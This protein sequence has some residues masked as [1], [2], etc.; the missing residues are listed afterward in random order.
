MLYACCVSGE[1]DPTQFYYISALLAVTKPARHVICSCKCNFF[2]VYKPY[3]DSITTE[4]NNDNDL[5]LHA[6]TKLS[7]WL[8]Y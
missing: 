4:M 6:M 3:E 7:G 5:N 2:R 1:L 8:R